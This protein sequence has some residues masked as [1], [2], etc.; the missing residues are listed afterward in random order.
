[1]YVHILLSF[2]SPCIISNIIR[3]YLSILLY[4]WIPLFKHIW[5][6]VKNLKVAY[7]GTCLTIYLMRRLYKNACML[8]ECNK[9]NNCIFF[10]HPFCPGPGGGVFQVLRF[11][12]IIVHWKIE[13]LHEES[14]CNFLMLFRVLRLADILPFNHTNT[15][16]RLY[17]KYY[18]INII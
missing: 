16:D 15:Y 1:M 11:S 3:I 13:N 10:K 6:A 8:D 7:A 4:F 9:N 14:K 12:R 2:W 5:R 17:K 18:I